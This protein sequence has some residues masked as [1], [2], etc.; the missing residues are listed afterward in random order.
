MA[1]QINPEKQVSFSKSQAPRLY[2]HILNE[3]TPTEHDL[4]TVVVA[5]VVADVYAANVSDISQECTQ[6]LCIK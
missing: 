4:Q 6:Q 3:A 1:I 2:S 5:V